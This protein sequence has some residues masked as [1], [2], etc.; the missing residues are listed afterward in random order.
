MSRPRDQRVASRRSHASPSMGV[1]FPIPPSRLHLGV[2]G[3]A[4]AARV[5]EPFWRK[6]H[7]SQGVA[8]E[9]GLLEW[10]L[11]EK[12]LLVLLPLRRVARHLAYDAL[13]RRARHLESRHVTLVSRVD[14]DGHPRPLEQILKLLGR[15]GHD[16]DDVEVFGLRKS[17]HRAGQPFLA[18]GDE[19]GDVFLRQQVRD[20][21][22]FFRRHYLIPAPS[23]WPSSLSKNWRGNQTNHFSIRIRH[24]PPSA[25]TSATQ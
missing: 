4:Q 13:D 3:I 11:L 9:E 2:E 15:F 10:I 1:W 5:R 18:L 19:H 25:F 21:L 16:E 17:L 8:I 20:F 22:F 6:P 12:G 24:T 23:P 7:H 14:D